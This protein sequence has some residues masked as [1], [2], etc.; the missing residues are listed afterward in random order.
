MV[1]GQQSCLAVRPAAARLPKKRKVFEL[2]ESAN[3]VVRTERFCNTRSAI[4]HLLS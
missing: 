4:R 1:F 3:L 2:R